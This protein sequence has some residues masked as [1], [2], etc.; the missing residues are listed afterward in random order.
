MIHPMEICLFELRDL[1]SEEWAIINRL[2]IKTVTALERRKLPFEMVVHQLC[3]WALSFPHL[4][5]SFDIDALDLTLVPGT[6]TPV[7]GG[8]QYEEAKLLL[9]RLF[10][11]PNLTTLEVT[12]INPNI[13]KDK[14][15][16]L[17]HQLLTETLAPYLD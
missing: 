1:E 9:Q 17:I 10:S 14:T 12:E 15:L 16:H 7:A 6:G 2:G 11:L 5:V 8:L 3:E 4:Y 13:E